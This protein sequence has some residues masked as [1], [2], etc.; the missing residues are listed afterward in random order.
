MGVV[1]YGKSVLFIDSTV[2]SD[3]DSYKCVVHDCCNGKD[4]EFNVEV[5]VPEDTCASEYSTYS[6]RNMICTAQT[7]SVQ[8]LITRLSLFRINCKYPPRCVRI[9]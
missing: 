5:K 1:S 4:Q 7:E 9:R 6:R 8:Q 2:A 3:I